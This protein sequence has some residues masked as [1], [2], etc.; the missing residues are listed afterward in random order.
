MAAS[1]T[2]TI[3]VSPDVKE[4]LDRIATDTRRSKSF[5]AGEAVAAYVDRE[6][7]IIEG[8]KR[9]LADVEAGRIVSHDKAMAEIYAAIDAGMGR[10]V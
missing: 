6:L 3:R 2:M 7:E 4:K 8:I 10:K 5:L 9:G 1:T